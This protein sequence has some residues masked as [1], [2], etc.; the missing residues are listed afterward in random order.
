VAGELAASLDE[1]WSAQATVQWNPH[2][3]ESPWEKRVLNL[4]YA[5]GE[6]RVM[7]LAYRYNLGK[8]ED[9]RYEDTDLSFRFPVTSQVGLVGRWLYSLLND[10]TV[11]AFVGIEFGRCCWRLRVLGRH[12]KTPTSTPSSPSTNSWS[13][14]STT[15]SSSRASGSPSEVTRRSSWSSPS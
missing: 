5:P 15:T 13:K 2:E 1:D 14:A 6:N 9:Q 7:N 12:L 8:T 3:T 4:R 11:D 10:E